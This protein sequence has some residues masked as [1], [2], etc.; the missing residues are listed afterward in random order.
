MSNTIYRVIAEIEITVI[1]VFFMIILSAVVQTF[2]SLV[3][4]VRA[5]TFIVQDCQFRIH[6]SDISLRS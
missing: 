5:C 2:K 3:I 4:R 1:Q 6:K